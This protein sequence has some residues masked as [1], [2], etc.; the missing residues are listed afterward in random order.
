MAFFKVFLATMRREWSGID[1]LRLDKFYRLLR[2]VL[3]TVFAIFQ[4][5]NWDE[6]LIGKYMN[7]LVERSLL[8]KDQ[9]PALGVNL[10][11]ADIFL[12]ELRKFQPLSSETLGLMLQP[13]YGTL[14]SAPDKSLLERVKTCVFIPLLEEA[15]TYVKSMQA[16]NEVDESSFG[17]LAV[18]LPISARL[19]ELASSETTSHANRKVLYEI[20]AEC[21]KLDQLVA[22]AGVDFRKKVR[23][24]TNSDIE[25]GEG[26]VTRCY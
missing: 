7:A 10:H 2:Q 1:R 14:A 25:M 9:Y 6:E 23:G 8:A 18:T 4:K 15:E 17:P 20:H 22:S 3:T 19:F 26:N 24:G 12:S 16:G 11:F 21:V 5:S 13:C